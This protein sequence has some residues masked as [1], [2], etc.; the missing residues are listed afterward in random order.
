MVKMLQEQQK[1]YQ[2]GDAK[3][4]NFSA[5]TDIIL[6]TGVAS[7]LLTYIWE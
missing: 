7:W 2:G 4:S 1:W 6:Q 5:E 3:P